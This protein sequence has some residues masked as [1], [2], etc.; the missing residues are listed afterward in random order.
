[1]AEFGVKL[2]AAPKVSE[3]KPRPC[4]H[5]HAHASS[6]LHETG[7]EEHSQLKSCGE[8]AV[9]SHVLGLALVFEQGTW[10]IGTEPSGLGC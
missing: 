1:M 8:F 5:T 3:A 7:K 10:R 2:T 4:M 9:S 6:I